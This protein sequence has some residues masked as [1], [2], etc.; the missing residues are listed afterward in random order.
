VFTEVLV[1]G[2][3]SRSQIRTSDATGYYQIPLTYGANTLGTYTWRVGAD[4]PGGTVYSSSFTLV[5]TPRTPPRTVLISDSVMAAIRWSGN[6]GRL[7]NSNWETYL[8]SCRRLVYPSCSGREGYAPRTALAEINNIRAWRGP[9]GPDDLLV[10]AVGYNDWQERFRSDFGAVNS[11]AR[12]AGFREIVWLT[13]RTGVTYSPPDSGGSSTPQ[14]NYAAMN[15]ILAD[16]LAS[17]AWPE[18][19]VWDY[20]SYTATRTSWFTSDGV[21]LTSTGARAIADW[22]SVQVAQ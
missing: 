5:R 20:A 19:S 14:S 12:A 10:I 15:R 16:E 17:G 4:T 3:W 21:H 1:G 6:L 8:E 7:V 11:A 9:A 22:L 13:Y 18:V 2:A